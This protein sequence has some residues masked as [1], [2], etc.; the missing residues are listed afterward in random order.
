MD[1]S[2]KINIG[3]SLFKNQKIPQYILLFLTALSILPI[4]YF[5]YINIGYQLDD[6]L[7]YLR[8]IKN[9]LNGEGLVYNKGIYFNGLTSP[10]YSYVMV[11]LSYFAGEKNLQ[12][13]S[14]SVSAF[15]LAATSILGA[16][17][18]YNKKNAWYFISILTTGTF[19]YF[20]TVY[21]METNLF[22]LLIIT[23]LYLYKI[24]N[25]KLLG[26][27]C[28]FLF[29]TRSEGIFLIIPIAIAYIYKKR[30][31]PDTKHLL[32]PITIL[33]LN[34]VFNKIYYGAFLP[35]TGSAKIWQGQSG[36][37]GE[38]WIFLNFSY[39][40]S[41]AFN[42]N[43]IF[44]SCF[45]FFITGNFFRKTTEIDLIVIFFLFFYSCFYVFLNIP[46]Y[47]WYYAPYFLF[48]LLYSIKGA[49][50]IFSA[51]KKINLWLA[52]S[53]ILLP[54]TIL[55]Y[56]NIQITKVERGPF[57]SYKDI[58]IWLKNNTSTDSKIA[59]VE[60]GT[61]GW[62][63][64]R[65]I[66]DILGLV[67]PYNAKFIGEKK[68]AKWLE[69]Y[70]P[71][72][73]LVH[74]PLWGHEISADMLIKKNFYKKDERFDFKGYLLLKKATNEKPSITQEQFEEFQ[75]QKLEIF[76]TI[77]EP[78]PLN[79]KLGGLCSLD[80]I[81]GNITRSATVS[82]KI[83]LSISGWIVDN[84]ATGATQEKVVIRLS[85][86]DRTSSFYASASNQK[87]SRP[88]VASALKN[89]NFEKSGFNLIAT[90]KTAPTGQY[91]LELIQFNNETLLICPDKGNLVITE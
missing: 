27:A 53:A 50:Y 55:F 33:V 61:V 28:S 13:L 90:L 79:E 40:F 71:D 32:I 31:I 56:N 45:I 44:F 63:S 25:I 29:L 80:T 15:S 84:T 51:L 83:P 73:I 43:H 11:F 22:L 69:H 64:E 10:L 23:S 72:Y 1:M 86:T 67:N 5:S 12:Y 18:F 39:L 58:G 65:Y 62:Y 42:N 24:D 76:S 36:L 60:I 57:P 81:N 77:I 20:Y 54:F 87:I 26:I 70:E 21:G 9:L 59:L 46:N 37:W 78:K 35:E 7:I 48:G 88:D 66:I 74:D 82:R 89:P 30:K 38:K 6:A 2:N 47:H 85:S 16:T 4:M 3:F 75:R 41:W 8:Y 68:F 14:I 91:N 49:S 34:F 19:P 52:L 17:L